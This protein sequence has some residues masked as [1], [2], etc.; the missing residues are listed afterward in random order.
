MANLEIRKKTSTIWTHTKAGQEVILSSGFFRIY[1]DSFELTEPSGVDQ[2]NQTSRLTPIADVRV[3]DDTGAGTEETFVTGLALATRLKELNY[4]FFKA[5]TSSGDAVWGSITGTI[6]DQT[7]LVNYVAANSGGAFEYQTEITANT[8]LDGTQKGLNKVYPVNNTAARTITITTGDY[9]ENDVINIERRGQGSVEII[10]DT[11]VRIRGVRDIENRYFINDPNSMVAVICRGS[12]EFAIVGNLKRGYTGAVTTSSYGTLTEGDTGVDV[13][14]TGTG[15]S[16]NMLVSVSANATLNSFTVNSPTSL[17]LNMDAVG[18]A[19]DT[20][21]VTYDNGD[22]FVDTDAITIASSLS[23]LYSTNP[24]EYGWALFKLKSSQTYAVNVRRSSDSATTDVGFDSSG[25]VS[26]SSPV[27]AGGTFG[28]WASTDDVFIVTWYNQGSEGAGFNQ[29]QS[30]TTQQAKLLSGGALIVQDTVTFAEYDGSNDAYETVSTAA[31]ANN[32]LTIFGNVRSKSATT[33]MMAVQFSS[34]TGTDRML[35]FGYNSGNTVRALF[36][37]EAGSSTTVNSGATSINTNY[38]AVA[39]SNSTNTRVYL[40]GVAGTA[41]AA[42]A[43]TPTE[44]LSIQMGGRQPNDDLVLD[45]YAS[46]LIFYTSDEESNISAIET[47]IDS[48]L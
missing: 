6:T 40:D 34:S 26:L 24:F 44:A 31:W 42:L 8:T 48:F 1:N 10:A 45:G 4:P 38:K 16:D 20:V 3:Y 36:S 47:I 25:K 41:G 22:V 23:F 9:V 7:D 12:E 5:S 15:F 2:F 13:A 19:S 32:D 18:S 43:N 29:T 46:Y 21:T 14:V 39:V 28:T 33:G 17:T 30:D 11:G 27:S 37:N 35:Q